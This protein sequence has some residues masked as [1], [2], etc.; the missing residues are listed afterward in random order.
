[1]TKN[2]ISAVILKLVTVIISACAWLLLWELLSR[3]I[4]MDFIFPGVKATLARLFELIVTAQFWRTVLYSL[5]RILL[6]LALGVILGAALAAICKL[7][8]FSEPFVS[9][10]LTVTKSTPVA[11]IVMVMW[12]IIGSASLPTVIAVMMVAPIIWQNLIDAYASIDKNLVEVARVFDFSRFKTFRYVY[13]PTLTKYLIP[14]LLT[15]L[16][17]AWKSGIAAEIISYT[18]MKMNICQSWN[19]I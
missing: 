2:K 13:A 6:G 19:H 14:A 18:S 7:C 1:M 8:P 3:Q 16:G 15:S 17:R 12:V 9:I 11:S 10:G 4:D 5:A